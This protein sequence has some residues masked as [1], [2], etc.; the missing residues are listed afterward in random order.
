MSEDVL[1]GIV[2]GKYISKIKDGSQCIFKIEVMGNKIEN[3]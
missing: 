2:I 1:A 3:N